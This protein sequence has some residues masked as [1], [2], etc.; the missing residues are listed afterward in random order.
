MTFLAIVEKRG[1]TQGLEGIQ[2][3]WS[4]ERPRCTREDIRVDLKYDKMSQTWFVWLRDSANW[5]AAVNTTNL[6]VPQNAGTYFWLAQEL[7][8]FTRTDWLTVPHGVSILLIPVYF[9]RTSPLWFRL[10]FSAFIALRSLYLF[11]CSLLTTLLHFFHSLTMHYDPDT[12]FNLCNSSTQLQF[13][14]KLLL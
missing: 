4:A 1:N 10:P 13:E 2:T 12:T 11:H 9:I 7:L 6:P 8:G 5:R 3:S 14:P